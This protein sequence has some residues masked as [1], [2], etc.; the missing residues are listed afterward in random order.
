MMCLAKTTPSEN[1]SNTQGHLR[2]N[3][4]FITQSHHFRKQIKHT[5]P[6]PQDEAHR[7]DCRTAAKEQKRFALYL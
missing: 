7:G 5:R 2:T 3:H 6:P 1:K 4:T